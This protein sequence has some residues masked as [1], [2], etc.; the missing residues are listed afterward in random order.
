MLILLTKQVVA[1]SCI[2][3]AI[4]LQTVKQVLLRIAEL[5]LDLADYK[6]VNLLFIVGLRRL[7][8]RFLPADLQIEV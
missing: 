7:I 1:C 4:I 5:I 3:L 2:V 6:V 8:T